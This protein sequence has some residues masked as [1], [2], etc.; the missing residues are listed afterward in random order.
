MNNLKF[1]LLLCISWFIITQVSA[2]CPACMQENDRILNGDF[3]SGNVGFTSSLDY[4]TFFPFICTL[5]TENNYAIGNNA[6]LFHS[7]FTGNDHT[8]P[9]SGDFFIANAPGSAGT[10]VWCQELTVYP[11]TDYTLTFWARDVADN[12]NPHP[13]ALLIPVFNSVAADDTLI[14]QG[15]WSSLTTTW[16][17]GETTV[18]SLCII[19]VQTE[20]GGN[21]FGLD[22]IS[23]T[24]CEPIVLSQPAFAGFDTTLCSNTPLEIG[25]NPLSGYNYSWDVSFGLS[26]TDVGNPTVNIENTSD[27]VFY[28]SYVVERDSA[29]V[30]CLA[31]DT[32]NI[33]ILPIHDV[34][35]GNDTTL[36]A[37]DTIQ[38]SVPSLWETIQWSN[39]ET[40]NATSA[41]IGEHSILVTRGQC[42]KSDAILIS[43][44]VVESTNLPDS[45]HHCN[46][47]PLLLEAPMQGTWLWNGNVA[48][49]PI[50]ADTTAI[51]YFDYTSNGC[52][53]TDTLEISLFEQ[54]F[55]L[56]ST[57]TILCD[58]TSALLQS[59]FAG[60]WNTGIF[61]E[62]IS[63]NQSG[64]YSI[65]V[66]N[67]PCVSYDTIAVYPIAQ[68]VVSL[69][70]D[71][72]FCEDYPIVLDAFAPQHSE[73]LWSTGDTSA[74]VATAGTGL[75]SVVVSNRC[76]VA[77]DEIAI[78]NFQ[79][80]WE[81]FVPSCFTPNEDTFNESWFVSGYNIASM[82]VWIYNRLGEAIFYSPDGKVG[83]APGIAVGDDVY[84]YRIQ[85]ITYNGEE[86]VKTGGIYLVR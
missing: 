73:Y 67:G 82:Q 23:L 61:A 53:V 9:P 86:V 65:T 84:N 56:L 79:C 12:A 39:G 13:L 35:I 50:V 76:G 77:S 25:I 83:W 57:D 55:A 32:V 20:T 58:G 69:G 48:P 54:H 19:D 26:S 43:A 81:I 16:N 80:S 22:D 37:L 68:P 6:T 2:Q 41:G 27:S 18:L 1:S 85:A 62:T 47:S 11:Q 7:D 60:S 14:A 42:T 8:N 74:T 36:C 45:I 40:S 30:G 10:S 70:N 59:A 44:V 78:D 63:I 49:N 4:V 28:I 71:T 33:S 31:S 66:E 75:Y 24:A 21:D 52:S 15:G 5:C 64:A 72:T 3:E 51:Y 34:F 46:T 38:L 29:N 17:S